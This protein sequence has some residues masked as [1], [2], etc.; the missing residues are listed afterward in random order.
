MA[1][2]DVP[3]SSAS[4]ESRDMAILESKEEVAP[5]VEKEEVE[6]TEAE[7]EGE[8]ETHEAK[9]PSE[10][11]E[12]SDKEVK[13]E[14]KR[15][16]TDEEEEEEQQLKELDE[17][18]GRPSF[19]D[20]QKK[21]P[22]IFSDFP[23]IRDIYHRDAITFGA[24]GLFTSVEE[25]RESS[26]KAGTL[27]NVNEAI[28]QGNFEGILKTLEEGDLKNFAEDI[29]KALHSINPNLYFRLSGPIFADMLNS[30]MRKAE[31]TD[32]EPL[33]NSVL[34]ICRFLYG[35]AELPKLSNKP[36]DPRLEEERRQLET[37]RSQVT[38]ERNSQFQNSTNKIIDK[39]LDELILD[40]LDPRNELPD[41]TKKSILREVKE[42]I[43]G[44]VGK[45]SNLKE[46]LK[47]LFLR[48]EKRGWPTEL[49]SQIISRYLGAVKPSIAALKSQIKA[50]ATGKRTA[51]TGPRRF[52]PRDP[53]KGSTSSSGNSRAVSASRIDP[54]K[55]DWR[56]TSDDDILSE[57]KVVLK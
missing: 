3:I 25:A 13:K 48:A 5:E 14:T 49:K 28:N 32:S 42:R 16:L 21:Y 38:A 17:K 45:N 33:K 12:E 30:A 24:S 11:D 29:P 19:K 40:G 8:T 47:A 2:L 50:E 43:N 1:D 15:L 56:K 44:L 36:V 52:A 54:K 22:N 27:D 10:D 57:G 26:V 6:E 39:R 9:P 41:F 18:V 34:N 23:E 7:A 35:K 4:D 20:I 55:V 46:D 51:P 53:S 31:S 37:E